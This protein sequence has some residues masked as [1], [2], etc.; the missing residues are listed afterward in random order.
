MLEIENELKK[1]NQKNNSVPEQQAKTK[2][3]IFNHAT[4]HNEI[5][6]YTEKSYGN[7]IIP[8]VQIKLPRKTMKLSLNKLRK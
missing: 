3:F 2:Y 6:L 8:Q 4:K 1:N 5:F 7:L